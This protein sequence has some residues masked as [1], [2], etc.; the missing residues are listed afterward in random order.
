VAV[1]KKPILKL[2]SDNPGFKHCDACK[3]EGVP[4][5]MVRKSGY[6]IVICVEPVSCR[7]RYEKSSD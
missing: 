4:M 2:V 3:I 5:E 6:D 1:T 7:R